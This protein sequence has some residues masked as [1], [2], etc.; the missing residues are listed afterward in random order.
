MAAM[1]GKP[2]DYT[3][4]G[5][6]LASVE[7]EISGGP[8]PFAV[9]GLASRFLANISGGALAGSTTP[10]N[11]A[12]TNTHIKY[13]MDEALG[14]SADR[15]NADGPAQG[16][17]PEVRSPTWAVRRARSVRRHDRAAGAHHARHRRPLRADLS[18]ADAE[19]RRQGRGQAGS[20]RAARHPDSRAL[21]LQPAGADQGVRRS[22]RMGA[23]GH[24]AGGRRSIR[25]PEQRRHDVHHPLRPND[26]GG[27]KI[28]K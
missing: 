3:E 10:S 13:T 7:I 9:E 27:I 20:A 1:L 17:R 16:R 25:R 5:R 4:K 12:V 6:Q 21:R 22:R 2:P 19:P 15:S 8:R 28:T 24:E 23:P 11:R 26:P 18:A 14:L